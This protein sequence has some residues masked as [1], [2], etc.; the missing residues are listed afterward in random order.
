[1]YRACLQETESR[2]EV[3]LVGGE[4]DGSPHQSGGFPDM[5]RNPY[6]GGL[7]VYVLSVEFKTFG[8]G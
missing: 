4:D 6:T 8:C 2:S 7:Y 5:A 1:M 3:C